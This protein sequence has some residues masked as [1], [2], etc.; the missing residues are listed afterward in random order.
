MCIRDSNKAGYFGVTLEQRSRIKPYLAKVKR[1]NATCCVKVMRK[2]KLLRLDQATNVA[3][4]R[5][6]SG[7]FREDTS[8]IMQSRCSFQDETCLYLVMDFMPGGDL[9]Q[10]L[11]N[12]TGARGAFAP[13]AARFYAAEV[14]LA[15]EF[16]HHRHFVYRDLKPE[17]VLVDANGHVKLADLG[18]CKRVRP[19]ERT[20]TTC[21]T[22][23]YMAPE[24]MLS[25]GYGRSADY[26]S[27]GVFLYE[28]LAGAAPERRGAEALGSHVRQRLARCVGTA[29]DSERGSRLE[30]E[31]PREE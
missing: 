20:Y 6:L 10:M 29:P 18:F 22:S 11:V 25:Q 24:V 19:G 3:R 31:T 7:A 17:N 14:F 30:Q 23:D 27:F 13:A 16:L 21:G 8:F 1:T 15:L 5:E 12:G 9:F 28:L 4:E 2:K 26:W